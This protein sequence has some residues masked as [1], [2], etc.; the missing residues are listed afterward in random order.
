METAVQHDEEVMGFWNEL[1]EKN[2]NAFAADGDKIFLAMKIAVQCMDISY[3]QGYLAMEEFVDGGCG[4]GRDNIPLWEYLRPS[5]WIVVQISFGETPEKIRMLLGTLLTAYQ[6]T[7][8]QAVQGFVYLVSALMVLESERADRG[9]A[10]FRS[11]VPAEEQAAFDSY[12][13]SILEHWKAEY[14]A[15]DT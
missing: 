11:L 13:Q 12:F 7:G 14:P 4:V 6:Y 3:R 8:Y 1:I 5:V 10:F 9:L 15:E 2:G